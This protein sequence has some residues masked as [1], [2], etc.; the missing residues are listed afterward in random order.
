MD[1]A[2]DLLSEARQIDPNHPSLEKAFK[3]MP[4]TTSSTDVLSEIERL[5]QSLK[6]NVHPKPKKAKAKVEAPAPPPDT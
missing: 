1:Q 3:E 4:A 5:A 6:A 2:E